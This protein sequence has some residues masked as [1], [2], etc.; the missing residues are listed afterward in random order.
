M[1]NAIRLARWTLHSITQEELRDHQ[2]PLCVHRSPEMDSAVVKESMLRRVAMVQYVTSHSKGRIQL[3]SSSQSPEEVPD[4]RER[5]K[6]G[7]Q[8]LMVV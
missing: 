6:K 5:A 2:A 7:L 8:G 1:L 4:R 3:V